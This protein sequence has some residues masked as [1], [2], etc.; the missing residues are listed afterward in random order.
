MTRIWA[1]VLTSLALGCA[2]STE[3]SPLIQLRLAEYEAGVEAAEKAHFNGQE[4]YLNPQVAIS[5]QDI[6]QVGAALGGES[7]VL[8]VQFSA[9][10][11]ERLRSTTA[12]NIGSLMAI[13]FEGRIVSI[14]VIRDELSMDRADM[15]IPV[16]SEEEGEEV[17]KKVR[18]R[19][20]TG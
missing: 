6:I 16:S 20:P 4:V 5:D 7:V 11:T 18:A 17:I 13:L 14:P 3:S 9:E 2:T 19:W 10:G 15:V 1:A 12:Q 8:D